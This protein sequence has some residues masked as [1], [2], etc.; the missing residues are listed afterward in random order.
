MKRALLIAYHFPPLVG[1]SGVQRALQLALQLPEFGWQPS[2][3]T[4]HPRAYERSDP[5][6][7]AALPKDLEQCRAFALDSARHLAIAGRYPAW[8]ARPDRYISWVLGALPA[9]LAM[10][11]RQR[12]QV[13]WSTYPVPSAHLIGYWLSRLSGLPWVAD[14]RD[15][16]AHEGY[17]A[18]AATW[19]SYLRVEQKVARRAA[20]LVFTTPGAARLYRERYPS[21]AGD[22]HVVENGF[23]ESA[24]ARA[25]QL[26]AGAGPLHADG[27]TLLHSGIVYPDWR[28]PGTL[29]AALRQ[30][31]ETGLAG[32]SRLRLRFR[33]PVHETWLLEQAAAAGVG[34]QVE[35]LPALPYTEALA[36]M[37][38]ADALLALQADSCADQIPAKVYEYLRADR[39][40]LGLVSGDS[41][42]L[43]RRAGHGPV[44]A[45]E[46]AQAVS[47]ALAALIQDAAPP[48]P[49]LALVRGASRRARSA[50]I[51]ALLD[52]Y[53]RSTAPIP[54]PH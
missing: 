42:D 48:K 45:L 44:A 37:L 15:P 34:D 50:E 51:A 54:L 16:M 18:D 43:L 8:L 23:D 22:M 39:P 9:G 40:L 17:P 27:F 21:R 5:I 24:F 41:A 20:A 38:R 13:I 30:L 25:E 49:S 47:S 4:A 53:G 11:R 1:S 2:V 46:D 36:E 7:L 31:R 33:A 3:L 12:P 28:H 26:A 35:V 14:F 6:S 19:Q 52:R 10:I 32:A 29:F